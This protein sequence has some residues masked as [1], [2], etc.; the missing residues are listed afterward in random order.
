M[1]KSRIAIIATI[2]LGLSVSIWWM[3]TTQPNMTIRPSH[4]SKQTTE[5]L[6]FVQSDAQFFDIA[7]DDTVNS[8]DI[9][10]WVYQDGV[11]EHSGGVSGGLQF[12][13]DKIA[14]RLTETSF[15]LYMTSNQC[16]LSILETDFEHS[17]AKGFIGMQAS[18]PIELNK[19][20][21]L[22]LRVGNET[23][24][25]RTLSISDNFREYPCNAGV[26]VTLTVSDE[27]VD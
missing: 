22:S 20:L 13:D 21:L 25:I 17:T 14:I 2:I 23:S 10:L 12:L 9:S 27:I 24:S 11:W 4:L 8:Y 5:A 15:D 16:S 26:A 6:E 3:L 1:K 7:L 18:T 19:E